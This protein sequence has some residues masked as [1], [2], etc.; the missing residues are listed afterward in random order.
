MEG[1]GRGC[2]DGGLWWTRKIQVDGKQLL[3]VGKH[4]FKWAQ[5]WRSCSESEPSGLVYPSGAFFSINKNR[6][7]GLLC[8]FDLQPQKNFAYAVCLSI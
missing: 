6:G 2:G 7:E 4:C 1:A 8:R 3:M 5:M